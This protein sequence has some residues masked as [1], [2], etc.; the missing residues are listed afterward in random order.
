MR[1]KE[2]DTC[3]NL[4]VKMYDDLKAKDHDPKL[5]QV[6]GYKGDPSTADERWQDIPVKYWH[7]YVVIDGNTVLDPSHKQFGNKDLSYSKDILD[8]QW[9]KVYEIK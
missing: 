3:Y 7:H 8:L 2:F 5:V 9:D 6:A 4:A 1:A